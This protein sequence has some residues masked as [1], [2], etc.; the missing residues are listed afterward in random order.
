MYDDELPGLPVSAGGR[1][2]PGICQLQEVFQR[3]G[4]LFV[5]PDTAAGEDGAE[6][7]HLMA[8]SFRLTED[9]GNKVGQESKD[10]KRKMDGLKIES[11]KYIL[12]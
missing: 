1:Q 9:S 4:L 2:P 6:G 3:N 7:L 8:T 11:C 10:F 5:S 12:F